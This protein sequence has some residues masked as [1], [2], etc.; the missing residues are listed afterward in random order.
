[1]KLFFFFL[2]PLGC[3]LFAVVAASAGTQESVRTVKTIPTTEQS[4]LYTSNRA[5]L[6]PSSLIKLPIGSIVP[7]GLVKN[8]LELGGRGDDGPS[9]R[10]LQMVQVRWE[11]MV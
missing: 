8:M 1:M 7:A 6:L 11:R 5:P 4:R 10:N 3:V 9:C 2:L